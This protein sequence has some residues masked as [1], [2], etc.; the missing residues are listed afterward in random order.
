MGIVSAGASLTVS[1]GFSPGSGCGVL[2]DA[3]AAVAAVGGRGR[4][5]VA[6]DARGVGLG[7][8]GGPVVEPK[9]SEA[10]MVLFLD[11]GWRLCR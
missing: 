1:T 11:G 9:R 7:A 8:G 4:R 3:V 10:M 2:G 5:P 6:G